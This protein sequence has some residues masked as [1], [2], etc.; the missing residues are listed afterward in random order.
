MRW[1]IKGRG[2]VERK[3]ILRRKAAEMREE[4]NA[5][6]RYCTQKISEMLVEN[7]DDDIE[8][9]Q[10]CIPWFRQSRQKAALLRWRSATPP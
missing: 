10:D 9:C 2:R 1:P 7:I 3:I 5:A 6:T 4:K 8:K